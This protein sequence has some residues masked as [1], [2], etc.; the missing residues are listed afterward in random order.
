MTGQ[1]SASLASFSRTVDD[2]NKLAKQEIVPEK[3]T[4]SLER[5]KTFKTE[6]S[7]YRDRFERLRRE[8]EDRVSIESRLWPT[9][10]LC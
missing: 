2:Y 4:K 5:V 7:D 10:S 1:I 3:Q 6:L 8:T 9:S